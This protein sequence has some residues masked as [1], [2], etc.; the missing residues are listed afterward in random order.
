MCGHECV[1]L[2]G[3]GLRRG[4]LQ[5]VAGGREAGAVAG[6]VPALFGVVPGDDAASVGADGTDGAK[7]FVGVAGDGEPFAVGVEDLSLPGGKVRDGIRV[8][9][10]AESVADESLRVVCALGDERGE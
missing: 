5:H 10:A 8:L 1:G 7:R 4:A 6:A 9:V 3:Q 2:V